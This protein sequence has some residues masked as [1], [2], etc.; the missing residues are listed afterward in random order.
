M[1]MTENLNN[2]K[3]HRKMTK[4]LSKLWDAAEAEKACPFALEEHLLTRIGMRLDAGKY[5]KEGKRGWEKFAVE[6][7]KVYGRFIVR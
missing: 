6:V 3:Q 7:G 2:A 4:I 5:D 1:T